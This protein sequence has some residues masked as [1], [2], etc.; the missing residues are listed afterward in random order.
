MDARSEGL[1]KPLLHMRGEKRDEGSVDAHA[2]MGMD[3]AESEKVKYAAHLVSR[4]AQ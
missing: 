4:R 1:T 2:G 3:Q